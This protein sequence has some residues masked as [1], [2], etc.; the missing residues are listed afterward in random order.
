MNGWDSKP[1]KPLARSSM[2]ATKAEENYEL[3]IANCECKFATAI[4]RIHGPSEVVLARI[5]HHALEM[6]NLSTVFTGPCRSF[7]TCPVEDSVLGDTE[8]SFGLRAACCRFP[9]R[10]LAC[11]SPLHRSNPK[12]IRPSEA[13]V[14]AACCRFP[15]RKL[16]CENPL[17]RSNP[18]PIR[19][20]EALDCVQLAAAF[21]FAS[22]LAKVPPHSRFI[23][24]E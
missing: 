20:S 8:R 9:L 14:R 10:K 1:S 22:L 24:L 19:Q 2:E 4:S 12:P 17:H 15:F 6:K 21:L 5:S 11:E 7:S 18:K 16:A 23:V 13:G 3:R